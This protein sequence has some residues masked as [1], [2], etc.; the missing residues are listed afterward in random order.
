MTS[1]ARDLAGTDCWLTG[2]RNSTKETKPTL[3]HELPRFFRQIDS[4]VAHAL[5]LAGR[6]SISSRPRSSIQDQ[7]VRFGETPKPGRRG[8]RYPFA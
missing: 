8:D 6:P 4:S 3:S 5:A 2:R 1:A 7:Q